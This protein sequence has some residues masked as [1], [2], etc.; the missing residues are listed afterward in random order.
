M[1]LLAVSEK[2]HGLTLPRFLLAKLHLDSLMGKRSSKSIR[3]ALKYLQKESQASTDNNTR[4][5]DQAYEQAMKRIEGQVADSHMLAK[6]VLSWITYAKRPL[7]TLELRHAL[8]VEITESELDEDNLLEI[9]DAISV[10]AGLVTVDEESD[11]IRL[12]H[13]TTQEYFERTRNSWFPNAQNY[14]TMTCITYLSF[15]TFETGFCLTDKEFEERLRSNPLYNYAARNWGHHARA[16]STEVE[17]LILDFLGNAAKVYASSQAMIASKRYSWDSR[18][19]QQVPRHMRGVHLAAY[20]GMEKLMSILLKNEHNSS[21]MDSHGQTPLSWAAK[22]GHIQVLKQLLLA[23]DEVGLDLKDE[24]GQTPLFWATKNGHE[25][26]AKLLLATNNVDVNCK[27]EYGQTPL[28]QASKNG[29]E[30]IVKLL[31]A[32]IDIDVNCKDEDDQT[33][34]LWASKNGHESTVKLLLMTNDVDIK[35]RDAYGQ[36]PLLWAAANGLESV[37]KLLL[38]ADDINL[39][40]KDTNGQAP[41]LWAAKNG[42][43]AVVKLLLATDGV[44]SDCKDIT[45]RT[46]LLWAIEHGHEEVVELLSG[47]NDLYP[48]PRDESN[49]SITSRPRQGSTRQW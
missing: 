7:T 25:L 15:D 20:F 45:G 22:N 34:L 40:A 11:I 37:T 47:R 36:T 27:D 23:T 48:N 1:Y 41:L 26:I 19:S 42:H 6:Q 29:H 49:V 30:S 39:N 44:D 12:V 8:A 13:Y 4:A 28:L 5:L 3:I 2:T 32:I 14:I 46:P 24:N 33:P 16:A 21:L 31:L 9:E 10:C 38:A 43:T 18:Y 17:Q 35:Y